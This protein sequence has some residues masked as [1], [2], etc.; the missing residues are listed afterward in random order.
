MKMADNLPCLYSLPFR[1]SLEAEIYVAQAA[2]HPI[3]KQ[4]ID[5][6]PISSAPSLP[7]MIHQGWILH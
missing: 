3:K 4:L 6:F 1:L 2:V 7:H 5:S